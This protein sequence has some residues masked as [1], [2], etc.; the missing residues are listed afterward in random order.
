MHNYAGEHGTLPPAA[1]RSKDGKPL[2]SW[3]VLLLPHFE[4]DG[5]FKEFHLDEPWD[6][7][8][9][10]RL[11]ERMPRTYAP[12]SGKKTPQPYTTYY[13][14]FVGKG[15]AFE[16]PE[17]ISL[18]DFPNGSSNTILITEAGEAVP[19]TKPEDLPYDP[20]GPL[21]P[22]GG[23]FED[24]LRVGLADGSVRELVK[25]RMRESDIRAAITRNGGELLSPDW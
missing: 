6:S 24:S 7:P 13:Q 11:L 1:V 21:P 22:L 2:L 9:N 5:L 12:F 14:V 25:K 16:G 15:T 17:G 23:V 18:K 20:N 10:I 8:H 4:Q 19:W 3:R